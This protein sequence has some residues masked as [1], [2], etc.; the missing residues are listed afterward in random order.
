[1]LEVGIDERGWRKAKLRDFA[2]FGCVKLRA[3]LRV[4]GRS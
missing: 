2:G 4:D 1:M 3:L